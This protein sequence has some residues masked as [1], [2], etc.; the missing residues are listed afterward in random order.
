MMYLHD[1]SFDG[2]LTAV[3]EAFER[4]EN[5]EVIAPIEGAQ[6][7]IGSAVREI[8]TDSVKA[9]RVYEGI[10]Y[11]IGV[12]ALDN[13]YMCSLS[14]EPNIGRVVL[15][16]L[17]LG[18]RYGNRVN[19][20]MA[21]DAVRQITFIE[22]KV[23]REYH[24]FL[25]FLRFS[26]LEHEGGLLFAEF[27]PENNVLP[28]LMPHFSD[29]L[30]TDPFIIHDKGRSVAGVYDTQSWTLISSKEMRLPAYSQDERQYRRLWQSFYETVGI[31]ERRN[32]KLQRQL[33]PMK[34]RGQMH[35]T[36]EHTP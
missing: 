24:R 17:R 36:W 9:R 23:W 7:Q 14:C 18:F 5:P 4:K 28:L 31:K 30:N 25:G 32:E 3:F 12:Q 8:I 10:E 1:G 22:R 13:V 26:A 2:L 16:Y 19:Q 6:Y 33:M 27:E 21:D 29:R 15:D 34:F 20:R 35:E 11:K